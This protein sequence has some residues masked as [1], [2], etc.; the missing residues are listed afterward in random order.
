M[1]NPN[2][3][4]KLKQEVSDAMSKDEEL[5]NAVRVLQEKGIISSLRCGL[6]GLIQRIM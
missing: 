6:R 1:K 4:K 2:E 5:E 3:W